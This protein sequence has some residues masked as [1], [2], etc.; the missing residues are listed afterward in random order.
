MTEELY[1][2]VVDDYLQNIKRYIE[3][4]GGLF[5]HITVF[6]YTIEKEKEEH[7]KPAIIHIPIPPDYMETDAE[8]DLLVD[9]VFP[10]VFKE[11][12]KR[13]EP[14]GIAYA[15]EAWVR[16]SDKSF[17]YKKQ[18]YTEL[19]VKKEVVFVTI[20]T[21]DKT[22]LKM[23]NIKRVGT[24]VDNEGNIIDSI[25]LEEQQLENSLEVSGRFSGLYK[26][27]ISK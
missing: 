17:D 10:V 5:P 13:F 3:E 21:Q 18:D 9:E 12:K 8:K 19:P 11:I 25:T 4:A 22:E 15:S 7:N 26:K 24:K 20:E 1:N 14:F 16:M 2:E 23:Y 6:A 27:L